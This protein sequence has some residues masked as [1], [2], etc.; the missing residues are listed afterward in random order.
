[1]LF[2]I[3]ITQGCSAYLE[4][5]RATYYREYVYV[6]IKC[7][8]IVDKNGFSFYD[9]EQNS[10]FDFPLSIRRIYNMCIAYVRRYNSKDKLKC[11]WYEQRII[12]EINVLW[13]GIGIGMCEEVILLVLYLCVTAFN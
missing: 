10:L 3:G 4:H 7:S 9:H 13:V 12:Y 6:M 5:R 8:S 1:M 2:K 11:R